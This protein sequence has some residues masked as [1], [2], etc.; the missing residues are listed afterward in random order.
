VCLR[1]K[2]N[3]SSNSNSNSNNNNNNNMRASEAT[4]FKVDTRHNSWTFDGRDG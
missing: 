2:H 1:M 4:L 3:N